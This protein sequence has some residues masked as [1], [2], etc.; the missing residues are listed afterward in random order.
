[1]PTHEELKA[2][3]AA[4]YNAASDWYDAPANSFWSRFGRETVA[5]LGLTPGMRVL[6]VCAGSGASAIPAALAVG[7]SGQVV[8]VDIAGQLLE[9]LRSKARE[10][11]LPQIDVRLGDLAELDLAGDG[12]DAVVC[13][14]GIF[15]LRDMVDGVRRLW[16]HVTPGGQLAVTTWGPG[17][18]EPANS[19][20]WNAVRDVRPDLY[21][22][23]NPW[24]TI[25]TP[26]ALGALLADAG[27][28]PADIAAE[29]GTHPVPSPEAW[30]ALVM[31]SGYRGTVEQLDADARDRVKTATL[32]A[33]AA[34]G[35]TE[36][37]CPVL[38]AV[39]CKPVV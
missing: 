21:R 32:D 33:I 34:A 28:D 22:G 12:F 10:M 26:A 14:F 20:F 19:M 5:R 18:F 24:D 35:V 36:I 4:A 13:V 3:A 27:V 37:E 31:G 11:D 25:T 2:R 23:F 15:F 8:A 9:R 39:A 1:M 30:W 17:L 7:R 16:R 38:Y 6:D 29:A